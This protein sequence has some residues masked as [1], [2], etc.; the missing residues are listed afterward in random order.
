MTTVMNFTTSGHFGSQNHR[1]FSM[2]GSQ[3]CQELWF[4]EDE[5]QVKH[6]P[7]AKPALAPTPAPAQPPKRPAINISNIRVIP[8]TDLD[9]KRALAEVKRDYTNKKYRACAEKCKALLAS[10]KCPVGSSPSVCMFDPN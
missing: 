10:V 7:S 6:T 8:Y 5:H 2:D 9:W 1:F 3:Q 4:G